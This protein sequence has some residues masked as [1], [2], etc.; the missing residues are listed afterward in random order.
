MPESKVEKPILKA[1]HVSIENKPG[2][3]AR[4]AR[5]LAQNNINIEAL[6]AEILGRSAF[7]RFYTETPVEAEKVL[8]KMSLITVG[9]DM[10]EVV[11]P[12]QPGELARVCEMLSKAGI[13]IESLFGG[14]GTVTRKE[15]RF[16]IRCDKPL[17]AH[18]LLSGAKVMVRRTAVEVSPPSAQKR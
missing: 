6:E 16:Y 14:S 2:E 12:N 13:N 11:L 10:I 1:L 18:R 5:A 4:I 7:L 17:E 8:R 3:L 9:M 15:S